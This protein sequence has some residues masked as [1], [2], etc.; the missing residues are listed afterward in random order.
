[1]ALSLDTKC[2]V[3]SPLQR[4]VDIETA[5]RLRLPSGEIYSVAFV[6]LY[7]DTA[8]CHTTVYLPPRIGQLL[9]NVPELSS[10]GV[11][12]RVA[13]IGLIDSRIDGPIAAA[14]QSTR[15]SRGTRRVGQHLFRPQHYS[16]RVKLRRR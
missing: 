4:Q 5:S 1:M 12:S 9:A 15:S 2:E 16:Y 11:R 13:A 8:F 3:V 6:R 10:A 14:E 7:A